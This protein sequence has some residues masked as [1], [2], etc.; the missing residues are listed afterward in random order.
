MSPAAS[1]CITGPLAWSITND[2]MSRYKLGPSSS[3]MVLHPTWDFAPSIFYLQASLSLPTY[4]NSCIST[5]LSAASKH[6]PLGLPTGLLPSIHSFRTFFGTLS[7]FIHI[8]RPTHC[9]LLNPIFLV[10]SISLYI[11]WISWLSLF[12]HSPLSNTGPQIF[13]GTYKL[14]PPCLYFTFMLHTVHMLQS[15]KADS[16]MHATQCCQTPTV[17]RDDVSN[18]QTF[19]SHLNLNRNTNPHHASQVSMTS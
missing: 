13:L 17:C 18:L 9:S 7:S 8:T 19:I 6:L 1:V 2:H 10:S 11:L 14:G 3:T 12:C 5:S 16:T 4:S 15:C